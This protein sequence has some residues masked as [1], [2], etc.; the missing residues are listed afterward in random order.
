MR[1][2][3]VLKGQIVKE[4]STFQICTIMF[5]QIRSK[6]T[7]GETFS[8]LHISR[9]QNYFFYAHKKEQLV[10][11]LVLVCSNKI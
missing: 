2:N 1:G 7:K 4:N 5:L 8:Q 9:V 11:I 3:L 6:A 10:F